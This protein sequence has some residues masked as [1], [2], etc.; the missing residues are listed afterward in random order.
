MFKRR[1]PLT[2]T[3]TAQ[4]A[5]WPSMGWRRAFIYIKHRLV[6]LSD[7]SHSIGLGIAIGMG[8]SFTPLLGTHF[9]QAG[10]IAWALRANIFS[11]MIGTFFGN[12]WTFPIFWWAGFSLGS[13]LFS[14][15]GI[16]GADNI[17]DDI[18]FDLMWELIKSEPLTLFLP[19][20]LGGYILMCVCILVT[21]PIFFYFVKAAKA[22]RVKAVA[23]KRKKLG[24]PNFNRDPQ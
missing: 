19:W 13:Y 12:P 21:Y 17:P 16:K 18:T 15:W 22:A 6:R 3:E 1:K 24:F 9:I 5:F 10:I 14:F 2:L 8:V 11:A 4:E 20:M 7:S 23:R